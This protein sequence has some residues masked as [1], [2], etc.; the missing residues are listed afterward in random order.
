M[1]AT[2]YSFERHSREVIRNRIVDALKVALADGLLETTPGSDEF[3]FAHDKIQQ[4]LYEDLIP[5][6]VERHSCS[7]SESVR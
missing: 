6:D 1:I 3:K 2:E 7:I 4:V 5:D